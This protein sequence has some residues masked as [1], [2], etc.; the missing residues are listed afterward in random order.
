MDK[1]LVLE[2]TEVNLGWNGK[3]SDI[4]LRVS[5]KGQA[6]LL[7]Y[8]ASV[9][10]DNKNVS[11]DGQMH[12]LVQSG[13]IAMASVTSR[14]S[15]LFQSS[16]EK[17]D[18][19]FELNVP[20]N[21]I[22]ILI[23]GTSTS[24]I[25]RFRLLGKYTKPGSKDKP[26][27]KKPSTVP[28]ESKFED[29][30]KDAVLE[31]NK[32]NLIEQD[33]NLSETLDVTKEETKEQE[34]KSID[35][36]EKIEYNQPAL[37]QTREYHKSEEIKN[38]YLRTSSNSI[39][40]RC[41]YIQNIKRCEFNQITIEQVLNNL[42]NEMGPNFQKF[43]IE[44]TRKDQKASPT[45]K[46]TFNEIS[47]P[48]KTEISQ[49]SQISLVSATKQD[50]NSIQ[51]PTTVELLIE[52]LSTKNSS[53]VISTLISLLSKITFYETISDEIKILIEVIKQQEVS[54][55]TIK[56]SLSESEQEFAQ[57]SDKTQDFILELQ[58]RITNK[59]TI[60][61]EK[62]KKK[63]V[64]DHEKNIL[65]ENLKLIKEENTKIKNESDP[66]GKISEIIELRKNIESIEVKRNHLEENFREFSVKE[67]N[68][69]C[70]LTAEQIRIAEFKSTNQR[71][72]KE[73][74]QQS[75]NYSRENA[76]FVNEINKLQGNLDIYTEFDDLIQENLNKIQTLKTVS[77]EISSKLLEF[78][79]EK[80]SN[81]QLY[82][83]FINDIQSAINTYEKIQLSLKNDLEETNSI[84]SKLTSDCKRS[85]SS[86]SDLESILLTNTD[87]EE[88]LES[89]KWKVDHSK[90]IKD[91]VIN[92]LCYFSDFIFSVSQTFLHQSRITHKINAIVEEKDIDLQAMRESLAR[93][94]IKNPV[95]QPVSRD[96]IDKALA[97]YL[98]SR[99]VVLPLPFVR[100]SYGIY[101]YGTK[102]INISYERNKLTVKVGGGFLP[103]EEFI[104]NYTEIELEKFEKKHQDLS[105]KMKK[106]LAKWAG[107][108]TGDPDAYHGKLKDALVIAA[109]E[110]KY[111]A[112]YGIKE[113][114]PKRT[115]SLDE[116]RP[117]TPVIGDD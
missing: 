92:E 78:R 32:K 90:E 12:I 73:K 65:T 55:E 37:E 31:E 41:S 45:R 102:K 115:E 51:I 7:K 42:K 68:D 9:A 16:K 116:K 86:I 97:D 110:H 14:I 5:I 38:L 84:I 83:S 81:I 75:E 80:D 25:I 98:N 70:S 40:H 114:S 1:Q 11:T 3:A 107:G 48:K 56:K 6:E 99:D 87:L 17:F 33:F 93:F 43:L 60:L 61:N 46:N 19:I 64:V 23:P 8:K 13:N 47:S 104:E 4:S 71:L 85:S 62:L 89:L 53:Q 77:S 95:Y 27:S 21:V 54:T 112:G 101:Y 24:K 76:N 36:K 106:F 113:P 10:F 28:E 100:D 15:S 111:S 59:E 44:A 29:N 2:F 103:I 91:Q 52:K 72:I 57:F 67:R 35:L 109:K 82:I 26:S 49:T 69:L 96:I 66:G 108:I 74:D 18:K 30:P 88:K 94:K 117:D 39:Y 79:S 63:L 105:P 50:E 34:S 58:Q 20:G 22:K